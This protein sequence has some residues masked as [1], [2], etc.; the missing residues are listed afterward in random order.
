MGSQEKTFLDQ[1]AP[2][3]WFFRKY[4]GRIDLKIL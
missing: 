1:E 2:M 3:A 4:S